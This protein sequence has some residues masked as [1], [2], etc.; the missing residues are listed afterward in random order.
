MD[1][2]F[3]SHMLDLF[4]YFILF[5]VSDTVN[6]FFIKELNL[7]FKSIILF[8]YKNLNILIINKKLFIEK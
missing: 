5:H 8:I 2:K 1:H 7:W 3:F 4:Y 6:F